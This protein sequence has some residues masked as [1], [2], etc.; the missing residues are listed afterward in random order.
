[1]TSSVGPQAYDLEQLLEHA[2]VHVE[3]AN[4]TPIMQNQTRRAG[5]N[6]IQDCDDTVD[7][8]RRPQ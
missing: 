6:W 4:P 2:I 5:K 1:M 3:V 8:V 7:F